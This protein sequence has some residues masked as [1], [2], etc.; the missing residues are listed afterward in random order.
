MYRNM[1]Q[2]KAEGSKSTVQTEKTEQV[3]QLMQDACLVERGESSCSQEWDK[4]TKLVQNGVNHIVQYDTVEYLHHA[5]VMDNAKKISETGKFLAD[6]CVEKFGPVKGVWFCPTLHNGEL[7]TQSPYGDQRIAIR[8]A[9]II[10]TDHIMFYQGPRNYKNSQYLRFFL[11]NKNDQKEE[12]EWCQ[13]NLVKVDIA[14]NPICSFN[15]DT[16]TANCVNLN[17]IWPHI[18]VDILVVGDVPFF[19]WKKIEKTYRGNPRSG[20]LPSFDDEE[21]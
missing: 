3:T 2:K 15:V 9:N 7:P 19:P 16:G 21:Q 12:F 8:I 4:I 14:A 11:V 1:S 18:W 5:T 6:K 20:L 13:R 17:S 10:T